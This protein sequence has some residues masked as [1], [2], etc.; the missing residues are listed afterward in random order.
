MSIVYVGEING[1]EAWF[2]VTQRLP[3]KYSLGQWYLDINPDILVNN[4]AQ[5]KFG[6]IRRGL[7]AGTSP[8]KCLAKA[9]MFM[10]EICPITPFSDL[11]QDLLDIII[12]YLAACYPW[13]MHPGI[14]ANI[15]D[16]IKPV[17]DVSRMVAATYK[18]HE[19]YNGVLTYDCD[20][21]AARSV[22]DGH[23]TWHDDSDSFVINTMQMVILEA[24][25][26]QIL[27]QI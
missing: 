20:I 4:D 18:K 21:I 19:S 23:I 16:I 13:P 10:D 9:L 17:I 3:L 11:T 5:N 8:T 1:E 27:E 2:G 24:K 7:I 22:T 12:G 14:V 25:R 26:N 6:E 15:T